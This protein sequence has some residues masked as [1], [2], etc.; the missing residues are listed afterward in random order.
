MSTA[1]E[2]VGFEPSDHQAGVV[3][4]WG[5]AFPNPAPHN[6]P[7]WVIQQKLALGDGLFWVA[8]QPAGVV[9][10]TVMAGYDGHRGWVYCLAVDAQARRSGLGSRLIERAEQELQRRGC[11]KVNLQVVAGNDDA[12]AFYEALGY[13]AEARISMGKRLDE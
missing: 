13:G 12:V 6:D 7:Q 4:L 10:G 3:A 1:I 9:V 8:L 2:I 11:R 5:E